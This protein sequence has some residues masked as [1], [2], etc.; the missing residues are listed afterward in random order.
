ML[1]Y[2]FVYW[3]SGVSLD[4]QNVSGYACCPLKPSE[5]IPGANFIDW[6]CYAQV[7]PILQVR[8]MLT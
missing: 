1:F 6:I 2:S 5:F 7:V 8:S 3:D 4:V